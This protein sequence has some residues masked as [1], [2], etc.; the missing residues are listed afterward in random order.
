[1]S[2]S[3]DFSVEGLSVVGIAQLKGRFQGATR[4]LHDRLYTVMLSEAEQIAALAKARLAELFPNPA[5]M[6]AAIKVG[7]AD[8]ISGSGSTTSIDVTAS[9]LPFL[10]IHEY[11]GITQPHRI[12][13]AG[14]AIPRL[15]FF[16]RGTKEVFARSVEHPGSRMPER[17][18]LRYALAQ[19]REA[20]RSAF[21]LA[22]T[23]ATGG[24]IR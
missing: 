1:M 16:F 11:G 20:I 24:D 9:G 12:P 15:H 22:V 18:Y 3:G 4:R 5:R 7:S 10:A 21:Q 8:S 23:E 14:D 13:L 2:G 19:R 17:S 6:Q